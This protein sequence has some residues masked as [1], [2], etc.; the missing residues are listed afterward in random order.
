MSQPPRQAALPH[1]QRRT[2]TV[3]GVVED[4]AYAAAD[5]A[6]AVLRMRREGAAKDE[7]AFT[8]VGELGT[9]A[10]GETLRL[11]GR[12][13]EHA[14][15]GRQF[16]AESFAPVVPATADGIRR[17]LGSGLV[18][19]VGKGLAERL[20]S[21]FGDRTLEVIA[22]ES[23]RLRDVDGIGPRRAASIADAVR[24]RLQEAEALA[25]LHALGLGPATA[26]R[27]HDQYGESAARVLREDP[28]LVA[29]QVRGIGF[30]TADGIGRAVGIGPADPRRAAAAAL[31]LLARASDDGHVF[32]PPEELTAKARELDVPADVLEASLDTLEGR[33]L[34][35]RDE[36][37]AY[38]PP[39]HRA[40]RVVAERLARLA[41][42]RRVPERADAALR[43]AVEGRDLSER[44]REAVEASLGA[45]LMVLTGGPGTGK[46]TTVRAIVQAQ[47]LLGRRIALAAPTG[48][49][50]KRLF[51]AT[52][53]E[54]KTIHRLLEWSPVGA[55]FQRDEERPLDVEMVLVD[56]ASMLD[57]RL[58]ERLL[59]A[60]APSSRLVLVGDVDQLPPVGPG[61][62]LRDLIASGAGRIVRLDRVFRQAEE[63]AIVRGAHA[64]L[65]GELPEATPAH[66]RGSGDLFY[67]RA[68]DPE[69]LQ[70][71]LLEVLKRVAK[72]Y[73]V[74]A[75]DVMVLSP[76][77]RGPA[78][79]DRLNRLLQQ[80]TN[81]ALPAER[82][83]R[84][85][86][87]DKVM[88][89]RNDYER[90]VF[91]GDLGEVARQEGGI[92]YVRFD[93]REVK[94]GEG[95]LDALALAYA[96]T[97]H[98]VQG[99]EFDVVVLAV[100]GSHHV[101]LH[102]ALVY[103]ALTR[104]KRLAVVV[105]DPRAVARAIANET[106]FETHGRLAGR[107]REALRAQADSA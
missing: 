8:A 9:P 10:L 25:F 50:A 61:A 29:E 21:H 60:I 17:F 32:L 15:H 84:I 87:G 97:V 73:G 41:R 76:M 20:V 33:G 91:N 51:E 7:G 78:G 66:T 59:R 101:L 39:L 104:A 38:L 42:P 37:D 106:A 12:W 69:T 70:R 99:S 94:Y 3:T 89:L 65:R 53:H 45:G 13:T 79:T 19:G 30:R 83:G 6:F 34:V 75:R 102:R 2:D 77:R 36:G 40:E 103:T 88:Q 57:V 80:A 18:E 86:P 52:G 100:H 48:R 16:R 93:G 27:I 35:I 95:D 28:Y 23:A 71:Q 22:K 43:Q 107:L 1:A 56:E 90:D 62:V 44:Q 49:A 105:G 11:H 26:R 55:T 67:V 47:Q 4:V 24:S 72:A 54:A 58:G 85:G 64:I 68:R 82:V 81:A 5:G 46:T 31:H 14:V 92:A 96:S 98:K 63:S 74:G